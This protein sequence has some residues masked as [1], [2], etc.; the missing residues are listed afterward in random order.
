MTP[1]RWQQIK[2]VLQQAMELAPEQRA[3]FLDRSCSTDE[4]LREEVETL[5]GASHEARSSFLESSALQVTLM[6]GSKIG[7]YEVQKLIGSGGMGEVYRARDLRLR[8]DVAIKILP[9]FFSADKERLR[10][11]EQEAQA[12]ASLNHPNI[13]AIFQMGTYQGAPYLVSE[14][15]EGETLREEI[16][17]G[18]LTPRKATEQ[19]AQIARGL[20]AA[21]EKGIIHRDL[22]PENLFSTKD[23][24]IKIL[25]FGLAKLKQPAGKAAST[26]GAAQATEA[27][28]VMGT[29]GYMSPEQVR[30][31]SADHRTDIFAF[32]AI[33]Y[34]MLTS[35]RAFQK[36]TS[37]ETMTAILNEEPPPLSQLSRDI[38]PALQRTVHRCLE[39]SPEQRFQ[40]ASDL[41]FALEALSDSTMVSGSGDIAAS[42]ITRS[43]R[44]HARFSAGV[45]VLAG[46]LVWWL[47]PSSVPVVLGVR[48]LTD[49]GEPKVQ[50][51]LATDGLRLYFGQGAGARVGLAQ[52]SING[53]QASPLPTRFR[54]AALW[55]TVPDGS[56]LVVLGNAGPD[57]Q[58]NLW[59]QPLPG[60]EARMLG[61]GDVDSATSFPDGHI[62]FTKGSDLFT[63]DRD[64]TNPRKLASAP[65]HVSHPVASPDGQ[66]IRFTLASD[67]GFYS[68]WEINADGTGLHELFRRQPDSIG[69]QGGNWTR[70]GKYFIYQVEHRGSWDL[71][72]LP[73]KPLFFRR[74]APVQLTNGPLSYE[75]PLPSR[76]GTEI[77][78]V[79]SKKH[80]ELIR[81][82]AKSNQFVPYLSGVSAAESRVSRDGKWVIYV[83]YPDHSLWRCR[84]DGSERQQLTFAPMMVYYP[85]ISPDGSKIAFSAVTPE[86]LVDIYVI[87]MS[88]GPPRKV[89]EWGHGPAWSPDGNSLAFATLVPGA[90]LFQRG[91]WLE[92]HTIDLRTGQISV[93]PDTINHYAPWWPRPD[94]IVAYAVDEGGLNV[95]DRKR[96]TWTRVGQPD[97]YINW[98]ASPDQK[99]LYVLNSRP[100]GFSVQ[101]I[102]ASDFKLEDVANVGDIRLINDDSLGEASLGAWIGVAA[103]GSPTLTRDVGSDDIYALDIKWP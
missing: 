3:A 9:S 25:D 15:L 81:Y 95:F 91:R 19:A 59:I 18:P 96:Q 77:F 38:P 48:Q 82:D 66:S 46:L 17:R 101:R 71:W 30:G 53:G 39:K 67:K 60:G 52:V 35:R 36:T 2:N 87:D 99:F 62:L 26:V 63:A 13:L 34:E 74:A 93:L 103:D 51:G 7:D 83:T 80:G 69:E 79:G 78:V 61:T 50:N 32:G 72:A 1:E 92:V 33:L 10:R 24:R 90:H 5:L 40:S 4:A 54:S 41:A 73:E 88:G 21:H 8:R 75:E 94:V 47:W 100:A 86:S 70:D 55:G 97:F 23:G 29:V 31:K 64:G 84:P 37:A 43:W 22:K 45:L 57:T 89:V 58:S 16:K 102:R 56:A 85:E 12:A 68:I 42:P 27:G 76:N 14:L 6:P 44:F 65:G 20:A 98:T 11:F 49:D 28:M